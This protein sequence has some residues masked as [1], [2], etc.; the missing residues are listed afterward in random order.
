MHTHCL[1]L[2]CNI[3]AACQNH[4]S[5]VLST[6]HAATTHIQQTLNYALTNSSDILKGDNDLSVIDERER[7][8]E[9][10]LSI[11]SNCFQCAVTGLL[12]HDIIDYRMETH[13]Y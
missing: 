3:T 13:N 1:E 2:S 7:R 5:M 8:N 11:V 6:G 10:Y 12:K 4:S 9:A